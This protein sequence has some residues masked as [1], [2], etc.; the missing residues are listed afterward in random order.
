M[1]GNVEDFG[2]FAGTRML[3]D[4]RRTGPGAGWEVAHH[5]EELEF[6]LIVAGRG[7]YF[8]EDSHYE[9]KPGSLVWILP[10][11][12]HRLIR[13]PGLDMWV[14]SLTSEHYTPEIL[15]LAAAHPFKALSAEDAI[16]LDRL[17]VHLSQDAD[18]P[19]VYSIG[20]QYA[21]RST[22]HIARTSAGP[23]PPVRHPAVTQA[24]S[25]IRRE[26]E[27]ANLA[28]LASM[29]RVSAKYLGDLL[30][31]QTGRGF[32]EWRNIARLERFQD[33]YPASNDLLTAALAAGF[34]SYTQF[35]RV[36][37]DVVGTT[38][39]DWA[40][41]R[42]D[43]RRL[44]LPLMSHSADQMRPGSQRL[45]W[46]SIANSSF[47]ASDRWLAA[48]IGNG[49]LEDVDG[50][51]EG[52]PIATGL[53]RYEELRNLQPALVEEICADNPSEAERIREI[54]ADHD[55]F[56]AYRYRLAFYG[57]EPGDLSSMATILLGMLS[58][59]AN[60]LMMLTPT[61]ALRLRMAIRRAAPT[62]GSAAELREIAAGIIAQSMILSFASVGARGSGVAANSARIA[63]A[64]HAF[65]SRKFGIDLR[66]TPF[67]G[68]RSPLSAATAAGKWPASPKMEPAATS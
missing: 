53:Q 67:H 32:V 25:L 26:D 44:A 61:D 48:T 34:G 51:E 63:D 1:V 54:F 47:A 9:L 55:L 15:A 59:E 62:V 52:E 27:V 64:V 31:A 41:K 8:L 18:R 49:L 45:I 50:L 17:Y 36:F 4:I 24:L 13:G 33:L 10:H 6:N 60:H 23:P 38:P 39:G 57:A 29:C 3:P 30:V 68:D 56:A 40:R 12:R 14:G 11:Q 46:M 35:H 37:Q 21:V 2:S 65:V 20:L 58:V 19:D 5:H 28:A 43:G 66:N 42:D 7:A 22:I 16:A